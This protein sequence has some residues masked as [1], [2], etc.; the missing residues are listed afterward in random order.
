MHFTWSLMSSLAVALGNMDRRSDLQLKLQKFDPNTKVS[1][2]A[3]AMAATTKTSKR[4]TKPSSKFFWPSKVFPRRRWD[5]MW[6][7]S[8]RNQSKLLW[9]KKFL[10]YWP[11]N[12]SSTA[13]TTQLFILSAAVPCRLEEVKQQLSLKCNWMVDH[14]GT[15]SGYCRG[16]N[17]E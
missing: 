9:R 1:D 4:K 10:N 16:G 8:S 13:E 17:L 12:K 11:D 14:L 2:S 15:Q 5:R 7:I 3:N 6:P